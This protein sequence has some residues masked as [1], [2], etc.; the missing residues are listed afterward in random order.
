MQSRKMAARLQAAT[1]GRGLVLLRESAS[2][3]HGIGT[4]LDER[5]ALE[6]DV[7]AFLFTHLGVKVADLRRTS[8]ALP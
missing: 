7:W 5:I 8:G 3:G 4:G 2:S 1:A 6:A